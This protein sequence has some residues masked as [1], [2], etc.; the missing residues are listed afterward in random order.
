MSEETIFGKKY[1]NLEEAEKALPEIS[2]ALKQ[3]QLIKIKINLLLKTREFLQNSLEASEPEGQDFIVHQDI[4][5]HQ[6]FH[7]LH[8]E[9]FTL[10]NQLMLH[11]M[12]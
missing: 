11:G 5:S 3:L 6:E 1:F 9:F 10:I 12:R 7:K 2:N 4:K 8:Y